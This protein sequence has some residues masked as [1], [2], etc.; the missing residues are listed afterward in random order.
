[1]QPPIDDID[2]YWAPHEK[3]CVSEMLACSV[4]GSVDTVRRGLEAL[5]ARTGADEL[6]VVSDLFDFERRLRSFTLIA[7][8]ARGISVEPR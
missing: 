4:V 2:E 3:A 5:V 6:I 7:E 1:M 8:A